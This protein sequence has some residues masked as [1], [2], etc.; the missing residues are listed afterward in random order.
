V[1]GKPLPHHPRSGEGWRYVFGANG[2]GINS[3]AIKRALKELKGEGS[4]LWRATML[5]VNSVGPV[6]DDDAYAAAVEKVFGASVRDAILAEYPARSY[7]SPRRALVTLT[8]HALF[9]CQDRRVARVLAGAQQQPVFCYIFTHTLE[10]DP[11]EKA[12]GAVHTV[13]HPFFFAW[14]GNYRP[15]QTDLAVQDLLVGYW[16]RMARA[17]DPNGAGAPHWPSDSAR[18][19]AYLRIGAITEARSGPE[20]AKCDF[21]DAVPLPQPHL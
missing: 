16:T 2:H 11:T 17:G 14:R 9:T 15:S 12:N 5:F 6:N 18:Y 13:E 8:T 1:R 3:R 7:E 19:Y 10:N 21:W 4:A 20:D